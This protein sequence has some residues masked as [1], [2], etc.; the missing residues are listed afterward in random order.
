MREASIDDDD[1]DDVD[2]DAANDTDVEVSI[3]SRDEMT[4]RKNGGASSS[5]LFKR[6]FDNNDDYIRRGS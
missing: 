4:F 5:V 1:D 3:F 2:L 6:S